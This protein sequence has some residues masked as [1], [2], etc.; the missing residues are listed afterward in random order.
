MWK[1]N[2][3]RIDGCW[4]HYE[5]DPPGFVVGAQHDE[6]RAVGEHVVVRVQAIGFERSLEH[7][8]TERVSMKSGHQAQPSRLGTITERSFRT[9][10][11]DGALTAR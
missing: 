4:L 2:S 6:A 5:H 8:G 11:A 10:R 7:D 9:G 3:K 1:R